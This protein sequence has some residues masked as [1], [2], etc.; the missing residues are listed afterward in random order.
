MQLA[1][2]WEQH[3]KPLVQKQRS[4][5]D[6]LAIRKVRMC[7]VSCAL[8]FL[9]TLHCTAITLHRTGALQEDGR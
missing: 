2:E 3:R 4:L 8:A 7:W 9:L 5:K 6:G 1:A